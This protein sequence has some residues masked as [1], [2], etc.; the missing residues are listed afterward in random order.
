MNSK[1]IIKLLNMINRYF[2]LKILSGIGAK[3]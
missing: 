3:K 2:D 1:I